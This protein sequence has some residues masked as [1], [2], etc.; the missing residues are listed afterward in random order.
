MT[1]DFLMGE[2]KVVSGKV[3]EVFPSKEVQSFQRKI[4]YVYS[5]GDKYYSDFDNLG[6]L[7]EKQT[8]GNKVRVRY[9]VNNPERNKVEK[10]FTN[11]VSQSAKYYSNIKDGYIELELIN[12]IF[13]Y[14]EFKDGGEIVN[15]FVGAYK[16]SND[17]LKFEHY[18]LGQNEP[19]NYRPALFVFDHKK[20]NQI[21][22]PKTKQVYK[23]VGHRR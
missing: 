10:L 23:R 8:I 5:V 4:K 14:R 12:G 20:I 15:D 11:H 3:I 6:T 1:K 16:I 19:E 2:T 9:S 22:D 13:N 17:S 18:L 7:D 21:I